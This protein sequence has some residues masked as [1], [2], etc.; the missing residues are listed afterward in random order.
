METDRQPRAIGHGRIALGPEGRLRDLYQQGSVRV[1][2]PRAPGPG[3]E[4]VLVNTAG[5]ITGGD[6]LRYEGRAE[7]G[8]LVL[9][10]QTAERLYRAQP[11]Q[12]GRVETV[13]S[14]AEEARLD[15]LPQETIAFEASAL[16]RGLEADLA[17]GATLTAVESVI[18]GRQAMGE[19]LSR[20]ALADHWRVRI[21][22]RPVFAEAL[23]I[24]GCV[25]AATR[26]PGTLGGRRAF[27]TLLHVGPDAEA[28]LHPLRDALGAEG[29]ASLRLGCLVARIAAPDGLALR[30][31]L[32]Q[33][34]PVLLGR[35]LPRVWRI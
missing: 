24:E 17:P 4:A 8:R 29:A 2:L 35:D 31:R 10:T 7:G 23:R 30:R 3:L 34:L 9:A 22:G 33:S 32:S 11:G 21:D 13:L 19:T 12:T 16:S 28:L 14:V 6:R 15:W 25:A 20:I 26:G 27:A 5:G 1:M 18:L